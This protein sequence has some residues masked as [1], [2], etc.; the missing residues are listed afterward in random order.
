MKTTYLGSRIRPEGYNGE[1]IRV[2]LVFDPST[3][4]TLEV[5]PYGWHRSP[6]VLKEINAESA[7]WQLNNNPTATGF[8][9]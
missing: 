9:Q 1:T 7:E 3:G 2:W 4:L 5:Y 6:A 8:Y